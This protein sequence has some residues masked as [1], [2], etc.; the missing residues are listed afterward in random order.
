MA[1]TSFFFQQD[2]V[3]EIRAS[4]NRK[5]PT[6]DSVDL[7]STVCAGTC[8]WTGLSLLGIKVPTIAN[9]IE[10][11]YQKNNGIKHPHGVNHIS[12][13]KYL[14]NKYKS[15]YALSINPF[16][17]HTPKKYI[18]YGGYWGKEAETFFKKVYKNIKNTSSLA[19]LIINDGGLAITSIQSTFNNYSPDFHDILI[20]G[21]VKEEDSFIF[22][23]PDARSFFDTQKIRPK[24]VQVLKG[25]RGLFKVTSDYL[26]G[27]TYREKPSPGG[28]VIGLFKKN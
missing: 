15:F 7:S 8:Y 16:R 4:Q 20:I 12:F 23:D 19:K 10:E 24:E 25:Y 28:I 18:A 6:Q 2:I 27:N 13:I 17:E 21:Y 11:I 3:E 22:L 26:N 1:P 14:G 5:I 9:F